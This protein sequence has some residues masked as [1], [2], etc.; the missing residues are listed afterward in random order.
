MSCRMMSVIFASG[1]FLRYAFTNWYP[2]HR[3]VLPGD[4]AVKGEVKEPGSNI[5]FVKAYRPR[6][7]VFRVPFYSIF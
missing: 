7:D 6:T 2:I 3:P 1:T 5:C 4:S